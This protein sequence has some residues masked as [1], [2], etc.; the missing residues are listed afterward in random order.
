VRRKSKE[1]LAF[2]CLTKERALA[3]VDMSPS[4]GSSVLFKYRSSSES[5]SLVLH[6]FSSLQPR[7]HAVSL[8]RPIVPRFSLSLPRS[9]GKQHVHKLNNSCFIYPVA[10]LDIRSSL[11]AFTS[12]S[13]TC[14]AAPRQIAEHITGRLDLAGLPCV[15]L[16]S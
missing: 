15:V 16:R 2:S 6:T 12:I 9:F 3:R 4:G 14:I 5:G 7:L 11:N 10:P 8:E 13:C 1:S